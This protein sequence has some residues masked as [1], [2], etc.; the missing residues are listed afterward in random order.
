MIL[1]DKPYVS[2]ELKNYLVRTRTPVFGNET[3]REA[4]SDNQFNLTHTFKGGRIYASSE[5]CLEWICENIQDEE[6]LRCINV[7]KN[8]AL[9]RQKLHSLYPDFFFQEAT[10]PDLFQIDPA[11]LPLPLI[12]KPS[13]GFF[14]EGV[15]VIE[16]EK[17]WCLALQELEIQA[18]SW[19]ET[20]PDHV[21]SDATFL[22]EQYIHGEEFAIDAYYD[23]QGEAVILNILQHNFATSQDTSD[24]LYYTSKEIIL[25][26]REQ[27]TD[28]LNQVNKI[29]GACNFPF[30]AEIRVKDHVICPIEFN[31]MRFAGWCSTDLAFFAY[32]FHTYHYYLNDVKPDWDVLLE[33]RDNR[34]YSLI[35]LT[36]PECLVKIR[37]FD[38]NAL[39]A[40]FRK[41]LCLR[42]LNYRTNPVFGF[43]F[44]QNESPHDP[45]LDYIIHS[46]LSEFVK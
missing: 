34:I 26:H 6:M 41:V 30:H 8:K 39:C 15:H 16:T 35:V 21:I 36:K 9:F 24:R 37:D 5:N 43:L 2:E 4:D 18:A 1:L 33:G 7:M 19:K 40:R 11:E 23:S 32:G 25:S 28:Y 38:Y 22:L 44:T 46:D 45:E 14:S 42:R 27:F 12:L 3:A 17:D 20:Y 13:V 29:F 31:P 10:L